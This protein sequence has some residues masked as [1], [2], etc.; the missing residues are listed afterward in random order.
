MASCLLECLCEAELQQYYPQFVAVGL[1]KIEELA[2][3][4]MKDYSKLGIH[5]ME[6]RKRLFQLIRII[7]SVA[8]EEEEKQRL[9]R[10]PLQPGCVYLQPHSSRS[11]IRR[12]LQF[13][14]YD[15]D[16]SSFPSPP[17]RRPTDLY[18][19]DNRTP[20]AP[21]EE[22]SSS[23]ADASSCKA[24][25][26]S[27][28][29][30][31]PVIQRVMHVSGYNYGVPQSCLRSGMGEKEGPWTSTDKIKVCVR[32]RPLGLR[33]ERRGELSVVTMQGREAVLIHE[34]KEAVNLK[35]YIL[36]HIFYFDEVFSET[37]TNQ[38][39][40]EKTAQPLIQHV[41][42][43]GNATCFAY[44]QT[45]AGKT[46]TMI[47]TQKSPGLYALAARDIFKQLESA[48]PSKDLSVWISFYEIYC[49]QLYDL[50]NGRKRLHAREDGKH[51]VQVVGLREVQVHSVDFLLEMILKGSRERSTGATGVNSDSSRSHAIIQ[52]QI[53]NGGNRKLG[54]MSFID[55]AGSER[56]ADA[57]ESDKQTK[58]EG[59]EIN[60]SLLALKE[61]IR[62][63]DQE[64]AHTPFRQSKL[65]QVLKDSFIG[66]SK[67]CMIANISPSH[68]ATEHTLNTLRYADRVKELKRGMRST[69]PCANRGRGSSGLSPKRL[70]NYS[71][72]LG[73]KIS[74]K[75]VKLGAQQPST[76]NTAKP[77]TCPSVFHPTNVPLSSTPKICSKPNHARG[78]PSEAWL[79]HTTPVRGA[80][81]SGVTRK[82]DDQE[83]KSLDADIKVHF[84]HNRHLTQ[85]VQ[86]VQPVQK[87]F[88]SRTTTPLRVHHSK[89]EKSGNN[90]GSPNTTGEQEKQ[91]RAEHLR[92]YHQQFQQPPIIYQKLQYQPLEKIFDRYK[93]QEVIVGHI[94]TSHCEGPLLEDPD[95]SDFSEDSFSYTSGHK[96]G[97]K[98]E[99]VHER[100]SFFLHQT[101][102][103]DIRKVS[104]RGQDLSNYSEIRDHNQEASCECAGS[105]VF[106]ER[107]QDIGGQNLWSSVEASTSA[108][109]I[110][111][112]EKPYSS[113]EEITSPIL[114]MK[115]DPASR[116]SLQKDLSANC[117]V[118]SELPDRARAVIGSLGSGAVLSWEHHGEAENS[119]SD[120][121]ALMAP[122]T[123]SLL[124]DDWSMQSFPD[125]WPRSS[126]KPEGTSKSER[127]ENSFS[128]NSKIN[129]QSIENNL[130]A[131]VKKM[132][133]YNESL[134]LQNSLHQE[135]D[136]CS[137]SSIEC[138]PL[139]SAGSPS[140]VAY[141]GSCDKKPLKVANTG[142]SQ[143]SV[144][145]DLGTSIP[146]A[147]GSCN[148]ISQCYEADVEESTVDFTSPSL[149]KRKASK[150]S[151][152]EVS[153]PS[154]S[155]ASSPSSSSLQF[156]K[157][158]SE[159][160]DP[161]QQAALKSAE[162][163]HSLPFRESELEHLKKK[164]VKCI[165]V[166]QGAKEEEMSTPRGITKSSNQISNSQ[167]KSNSTCQSLRKDFEKAQQLLRQAHCNQLI[168]VSAL[169]CQEEM[170]LNRFFSSDFLEYVK[171]L[172]DILLQ[173]TQH[174][175]GLRAQ[176]QLFLELAPAELSSLSF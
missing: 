131:L 25:P 69:T 35:E 20:T 160:Q 152:K 162:D 136:W 104:G 51:V 70:Q 120:S 175:E 50:L 30:E 73:E 5:N 169:C 44:G 95:D 39:V 140:F 163:L 139:S 71:S 147:S 15:L 23:S 98:E 107:K 158:T 159:S 173:K 176:L 52:I 119:S 142:Q 92:H 84:N 49:G 78:S 123:V 102:G 118:T 171:K 111:T 109:N 65:T 108:I 2:K 11:S 137:D 54:R 34:R 72:A 16:G 61:C 150:G 121:S 83:R 7:K 80:S 116:S 149:F 138:K 115:S 53:K 42:N 135:K 122:L 157:P 112:P 127:F 14:A 132:L 48:Q 128:P 144:Q 24:A 79:A 76:S 97:K 81:R 87:Q 93:P 155:V 77:R 68:V 166:H 113:E 89:L 129:E 164:L 63:L 17:L 19:M 143:S 126:P 148:P 134:Q 45:G 165:F 6:D 66:N 18:A 156:N 91:D 32:K 60:Q 85:R 56:A 130:S 151:D 36:Q 37:F 174:I 64:Q 21:T 4:T 31:G 125:P 62:A 8:E 106:S 75:K 26:G 110:D 1:Q 57:R 55:L 67:T 170:L 141:Q 154:Q 172:D 74:P 133:Q 146:S 82:C 10:T 28:E 100:L 9:E 145:N 114:K 40:Y 96:K 99:M 22:F 161:G 29:N 103:S 153:C 88:I 167:F 47:G 86:A 33:E 38:D 43:G 90:Y 168:E 12:Q 58:I 117:N 27:R 101:T 124:K 3:V 94:N 13:H 41:F 105:C 59:A 46:Y